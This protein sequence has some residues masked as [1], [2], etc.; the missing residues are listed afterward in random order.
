MSSFQQGFLKE[1][2]SWVHRRRF[3]LHSKALIWERQADRRHCMYC[4][5]PRSWKQGKRSKQPLQSQQGRLFSALFVCSF[6]LKC[7]SRF[8]QVCALKKWANWIWTLGQLAAVS[9]EQKV[10]LIRWIGYQSTPCAHRTSQWSPLRALLQ[11]CTVGRLQ[12][13]VGR[14]GCKTYQI[15]L[16]TTRPLHQLPFHMQRISNG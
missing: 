7:L 14:A 16:C 11:G 6:R 5:G 2:R 12:G 8:T 10:V 1:Q 9:K 15:D 13:T 4:K 3:A